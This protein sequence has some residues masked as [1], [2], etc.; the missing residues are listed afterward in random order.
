MRKIYSCKSQV[1]PSKC[2]KNKKVAPQT[3]AECV[4]SAFN[5]FTSYLM[6]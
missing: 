1:K 6:N 3:I 4:T 5:I 2:G